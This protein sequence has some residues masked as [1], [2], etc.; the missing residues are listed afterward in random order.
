LADKLGADIEQVR[1]GIGSDPRIGYHFLYPGCGYGGSC[2]HR[3][4]KALIRTAES[5]G[6]LFKVLVL[7]AVAEAN[8]S[9]KHLLL[10]KVRD[11]FGSN[12]EGKH[13]A[14]WGLA[15][16][17]N[18]NDMREATSRVII[19]GLWDMGATISAYDPMAITES[20]RIFGDDSRM[21][22][23]DSPI[24]ALDNADA[25]II[26]TEWKEFRGIDLA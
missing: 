25:L 7:V 14:L 3:D 10:E 9:Q 23:A 5:V 6:K 15:F 1:L 26:V 2:F 8:E 17:P 12:L 22:Y 24:K 11:K 21:S 16:K 20:K 18:T 13:L 19:K 4:V